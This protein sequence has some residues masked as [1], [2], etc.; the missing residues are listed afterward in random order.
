MTS[1]EH[2][3]PVHAA[4]RETFMAADRIPPRTSGLADPSTAIWLGLQAVVACQLCWHK[5]VAVR[6]L[7]ENAFYFFIFFHLLA[8]VDW[9]GAVLNVVVS[10]VAVAVVAT[11]P[12]VR[13][14]ADAVTTWLGQHVTPVAA[15]T[16]AA[17]ALAGRIVCD[18]YPLTWDEFAP[19]FQ[20]Q[21]F[22]AGR[23]TGSW[24]PALVDRLL[25]RHE[26][27]YFLHASRTTGEVISCYAP[28]HALLLTP[29]TACGAGWLLAPLLLAG[30]M[31][32]VAALAERCFGPQAKGSAILACIASPVFMAYGVSFYSMPA[33]L[34]ANMLF[35]FLMIRGGML[36][37]VLAGLVGGF[38]LALHNPFPHAL[39]AL[40][41]IGWVACQKRGWLRLPVLG[42][43]YLAVFLPIDRGWQAI[44]R[45]V[46]N[47]RPAA[48]APAAGVAVNQDDAEPVEAERPVTTP[49]PM[50]VGNAEAVVGRI[51]SL[52]AALRLPTSLE[53]AAWAR[54]AS[55]LRLVAWDAP[56]LVVLAGLGAWR[57]RRCT[58]AVLLA[59]SAA[60]TFLGY[61][62]T[63]LSGGHGWGYR[64]FFSAWGCLP[65]LAA[66]I[67]R[68]QGRTPADAPANG[69][70]LPTAAVVA[71]VAAACLCVPLRLWQIRDF[72]TR[73][74]QQA[75]PITR[76]DARGE[77]IPIV[78]ID[79]TAGHFTGDLIRN[80]PFLTEDGILAHGSLRMVSEGRDADEAFVRDLANR[81][82][83]SPVLVRSRRG[84]T[85]W[86]LEPDDSSPP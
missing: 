30:T 42:C 6:T 61:V 21:V 29:F 2:S 25:F 51:R 67:M 5:I 1:P 53:D 72:S 80:P 23:L 48:A 32:L 62:F 44:T 4:A 31:V 58:P 59:C 63:D 28:G 27:G 20:S 46:V 56:G 54:W 39:F 47:G 55:F 78:F 60:C 36:D 71:A 52:A 82:R 34:L 22:A 66:G 40:P 37:L 16:A 49:I 26:N 7:P 64:Y 41:W 13:E 70:V 74:R 85:V 77:R 15:G 81:H 43:C 35:A 12:Q 45:D 75:L 8:V 83:R 19:V 50:I 68:P 76:D 3:R 24:P 9:A 38:A 18:A 73:H 69:G 14:R 10:I 11:L 65:I 57:G 33:H 84:D 86:I 17:F 79:P